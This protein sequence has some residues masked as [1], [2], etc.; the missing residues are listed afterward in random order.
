[1]SSHTADP[2]PSCAITLDAGLREQLDALVRQR[3]FPDGSLAVESALA[4][5]GHRMTKEPPT[6]AE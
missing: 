2:Q 6:H 3:W 4:K 5:P 1:M